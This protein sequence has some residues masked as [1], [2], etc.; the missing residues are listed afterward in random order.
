VART[1]DK[2]NYL[3]DYDIKGSIL[4]Y[5]ILNYS[6]MAKKLRAIDGIALLPPEMQKQIF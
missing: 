5:E 6:T 2:G 4:G 1:E 3:V